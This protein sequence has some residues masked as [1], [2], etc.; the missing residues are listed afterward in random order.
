MMPGF[1]PSMTPTLAC[2]LTAPTCRPVGAYH[3]SMIPTRS[4]S[5]RT[6]VARVA[7]RLPAIHLTRA[8]ALMLLTMVMWSVNISSVKV[9]VTVFPPLGFGVRFP[10]GLSHA[11]QRSVVVAAR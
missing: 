2:G 7:G 9:L 8:D 10:P 3:K 1:A 4:P 11:A 6:R 5:R